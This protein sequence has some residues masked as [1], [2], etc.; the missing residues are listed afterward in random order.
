MK[1]YEIFKNGSYH[2]EVRAENKRECKNHYFATYGKCNVQFYEVREYKLIYQDKNQNEL[3]T[4]VIK[5]DDIKHAREL[6]KYF[7]A[8]SRINDL[9][10]IAVKRV[11]N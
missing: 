2:G 4:E 5:C 6:T 1:T 10:K 7:F 11:Y 9:Y 3:K 8:E